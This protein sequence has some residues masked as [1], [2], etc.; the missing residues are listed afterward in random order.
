MA[1]APPRQ[2]ID[3]R[4]P[5]GRA[6]WWRAGLL[7]A[8]LLGAACEVPPPELDLSDDPTRYIEQIE[9]RRGV[10]ERDLLG[11]D[12]TY[13]Q[14]RLTLYGLAGEGWDLLEERDRPS[15]RLSVEDT[16]RLQAGGLDDLDVSDLQ[17]VMPGSI[18]DD[19]E[20]WISLGREVV[21]RYPLRSDPLY[22]VLAAQ[23]GGLERAGFITRPDGTWV[24][25]AL[26]E[27]E[28]GATRIGPT[29]A[30][31]HCSATEFGVP[32]PVVANK[33]MDLGAAHLLV[34]GYDPDERPED[35]EGTPTALH[36]DL[37]PGRAD[38]QGDGEFNPFAFP[39]LGGLADMPYLQ[40][41][42]N[43][44]HGGV[45]TLAIR[46]ATLF[47]TSN[48][49]R[50]RVPRALSWATAS[51]FRSFNAPP[52]LDS[53]PGPD[54]EAG[55]AIFDEAGCE[56]CHAPPTYTSDRLV[57]LDEIG[58]DPAAGTSPR[59]GTGYYRIP[60]LRGVGRT[61]PYLHHGAVPSLDELLSPEREEPGHDYGLD[62][63][64][65]QRAQLI[66]FLRSI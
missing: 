2:P 26:F 63:D 3:R 28:G 59:R 60:S 5:G 21:A 16:E 29:C 32:S 30:Q 38:V 47:I 12:T 51:F 62:L 27:D 25:L 19:G 40:H 57:S 36:Y 7:L 41:N 8:A 18:P 45:A 4:P 17:P 53:D 15:R 13:A 50:S 48:L 64:E 54:A 20:E 56:E 9:Y 58:T 66:A 39:D 61:A 46:C 43:W 14:K 42:A 11:L 1:H 33:A 65:E 37:G 22:T 55:R 23:P 44:I 52:P 6:T 34:L 35:I 10:M 24:G 49:E 31:C